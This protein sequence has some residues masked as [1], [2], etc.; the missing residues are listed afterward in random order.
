M[1]YQ[2]EYPA[3]LKAI[4]VPF[5][6][7]MHLMLIGFSLVILALFLS[8]K[9]TGEQ[10]VFFRIVRFSS[11][12]VPLV[13]IMGA[14]WSEAGSGWQLENNKLIIR[15]S[16]SVTLNPAETRVA[17]VDSA[18]PWRPVSKDNGFSTPGLSTGWFNLKNG[19]KALI[20]RHLNSPVMIVLESNNRYYILSHPGVEELYRKLVNLGAQ[21]DETAI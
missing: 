18:G 17:L 7:V 4:F 13:I 2:V 14:S 6:P 10:R 9:K 20:F 16:V 5:D 15:S 21:V 19:E 3:V 8:R 11:L 12:L 1:S